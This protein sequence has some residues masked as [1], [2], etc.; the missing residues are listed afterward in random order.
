MHTHVALIT[1]MKVSRSVSKINL[2]GQRTVVPHDKLLDK[3]DGL[4]GPTTFVNLPQHMTIA[5]STVKKMAD[6]T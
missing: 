1:S 5:T 2:Y 4:F 6:C 3:F